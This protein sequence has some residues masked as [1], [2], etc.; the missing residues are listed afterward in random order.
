MKNPRKKK[1]LKDGEHGPRYVYYPF[2]IKDPLRVRDQEVY[3]SLQVM[4]L[5]TKLYDPEVLQAKLNQIPGSP[6]SEASL[7]WNGYY[8]SD[9][10]QT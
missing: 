9:L 1:D 7:G 3:Q 2:L 10:L 4:L 6:T 5:E 8:T